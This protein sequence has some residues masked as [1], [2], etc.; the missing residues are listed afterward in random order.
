LASLWDSR[1]SMAVSTGVGS[2]ETRSEAST[3]SRACSRF[4]L[5]SL[6]YREPTAAA[7]ITKAATANLI[8]I[9]AMARV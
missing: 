9:R 4:T 6:Q 7:D 3:G 1:L 5:R 8:T 2:L